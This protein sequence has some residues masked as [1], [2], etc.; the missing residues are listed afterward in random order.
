[1]R[2][3][4][5]AREAYLDAVIEE[6]DAA[7]DDRDTA[8]DAFLD[9]VNGAF[10]GPAVGDVMAS[11]EAARDPGTYTVADD[12]PGGAVTFAPNGSPGYLPR[13][14]VDGATVNGLNGTTTRP[15][16]VRNVNYVTVP[17]SD[18]STDVVDR[19]LGTEDTVR[20]QTAGRALL[21]ADDALEQEDDPDLREDRDALSRQV[22]GSLQAVDRELASAL[23]VHTSLSKSERR[24]VLDDTAA[25]SGSTGERAV[26]VGDGSYP[27]RVAAEAASTDALSTAAEESLA[28]RLRVETRSA[29]GRD[30]VRV[31]TR[32][33][34]GPTNGARLLLR[35]RMEGAI[36][37]SAAE[38]GGRATE[39]ASDVAVEEYGEKWSGEPARSVGAGLP[40][41]PVPGYWVTTVNAW[42]VQVRGEYPRFALRADVGT[43]GNPFEYVRTAGEVTLDVDGEPVRLGSTEPVRFETQTVVVVAVPAGPPGVGD[44][45]GTRDETSGGWPCP[46]EMG[47]ATGANGGCDAA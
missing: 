28:A 32:F 20:L 27:E 30:A 41:A 31:P 26:A 21:M 15:L 19:V 23:R 14:T 36:E 5:A 7:A 42:R 17:Y 40:V 39:K 3:R 2:A 11:R 25:A 38:A 1:G 8:T 12:G 4:T 22:D 47:E 18:V 16:A 29:T 24:G 45:D 33:V 43:P 9:R 13:T 44:V 35:D 10:D 6:L 37:E 34:D 46:G